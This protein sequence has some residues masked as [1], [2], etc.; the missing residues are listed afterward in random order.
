[1]RGLVDSAFDVLLDP[2]APIRELGELLLQSSQ[3]KCELVDSVS[4]SQI[5]EIYD[6]ARAAGAIGG[7]LLGAGGGGFIVLVWSMRKSALRYA[8]D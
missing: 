3:L 7:K 2:K 4:N 1:M 5:D 8:S 6:A